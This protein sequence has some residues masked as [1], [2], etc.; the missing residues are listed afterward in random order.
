MARLVRNTQAVPADLTLLAVL[1]VLIAS[2]A[3]CGKT[4]N[5][6]AAP[7]QKIFTS[8]DQAGAAVL[9][10]AKGGDQAA[11]LAIFGP[12]AKVILFSGDAAKDQD[13]LRDFVAA[14]T[15]MHRWREIKAGGRMLYVGA[16]NYLFP[17]PLDKNASGAWQFD[18][19]AGKDEILARRIGKG[20][21]SAIA[22]C[23]ALVKAQAEYFSRTHDGDNLKQY[24]Q[25]LVST[26]GKHDGLYW[27]DAP[28]QPPSPLSEISEFAKAADYSQAGARP[29]NR[30]HFRILSKQ[31]GGAAGGVQDYVVNGK[32]TR[33]FAFLAYPAEYRNSGVMTF[34][35]GTDGTVY[36]K[37]LGDKT[38]T[39]PAVVTEYNPTDGWNPAL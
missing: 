11:L 3:A 35:V 31:G 39:A 13:N 29:F 5:T 24:A 28:G 32:M 17:I 34:I 36:Q 15:Q 23:D 25:K 20:E 38:S 22:A 4:P 18:T 30:Y 14:Y 1:A 7:A 8:P 19:A 6:A 37:D 2:L 16:D 26:E 21:L 27:P 12:D 33:G 9:E 10:A